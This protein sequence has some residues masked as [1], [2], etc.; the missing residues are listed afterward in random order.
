L[1]IIESEVFVKNV[2]VLQL[3]SVTEKDGNVNYLSLSHGRIS[4]EIISDIYS[5]ST[6]LKDYFG[7]LR[8]DGLDNIAI[9]EAITITPAVEENYAK[10]NYQEKVA[11][12]LV[13][14]GFNE[15]MTNS[16][17]NAAY[18]SE[19]AL[20]KYRVLVEVEYFIALCEA[21]LP[22][23]KGVSPIVFDSLRNIY[24]NF[25]TEDAQWIKESEKKYR[26]TKEQFEDK[27]KTFSTFSKNK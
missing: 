17:T 20:I 8:I 5:A 10:D 23:L 22:Q 12:Y 21:D 14:N 25:T 26:I 6:N 15:I 3:V 24:K 1:S 19:E 18:F 13:G 2:V 11:N 27:S 9:P 4:N 7:I 16:I